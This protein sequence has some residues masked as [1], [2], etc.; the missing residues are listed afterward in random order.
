MTEAE[1]RGRITD[2]MVEKL[3]GQLDVRCTPR[4]RA[5]HESATRDNVYHFARG[6][7]DDNPLWLSDDYAKGST[8][9]GII[10]PPL[11]L[12]TCG[13]P[14]QR[15][16]PGI[17]A[18]WSAD[19][20][21]FYLPTREE[22]SVD[23]TFKLVELTEKHGRFSGKMFKQVEESEYT[24]QRGEV[25]ARCRRLFMRMERSASKG[26][27]KYSTKGR[28]QYTS[29]ELAGIEADYRGEVRRGADPRYWEDVTIGEDLPPV[30]K[31]PLTIT[32]EV[33][34]LSAIGGGAFT[35]VHKM[36]FD[37]WEE[38]PEARIFHPDTNVPEFPICVHWEDK[39]AQEV[40]LPAA[41][42]VGGER[43]TWLA[44]LMTNWMGDDGFLKKH[45]VELRLFNFIGDTTWC[46]GKVTKKYI[47]NGEHLVD[48][49]IW[50]EN[51]R[52]E[53]TAPGH[54]TVVLPSRDAGTWPSYGR[55]SE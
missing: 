54:A 51:Q 47:E 50:A 53:V 8:W 15:G 38:H 35:Y 39:F 20:W 42:D 34:W 40:G 43:I 31:G 18:I 6:I 1:S 16:F 30:V 36:A 28:H 46:K 25:I 12:Q 33:A 10:A 27:G 3:R 41:Y 11:F 14:P 29:E 52:G 26:R 17:H 49:D 7:G 24:N 37:Y 9:G 19:D 5:W 13:Y 32:S 22:D 55:E 2:E 23:S 45:N 44:H 21:E 48:C 4:T